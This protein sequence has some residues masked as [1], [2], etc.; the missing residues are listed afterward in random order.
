ME[1]RQNQTYIS[2]GISSIIF[3]FIILCLSVFALLSVNSA[4]QS[5]DSVMRNAE[6]VT[7]YYAADSQ[8][9]RWIH[10]LK[11]GDP[12]D[13]PGLTIYTNDFPHLRHADAARGSGQS[14]IRNPGVSGDKQ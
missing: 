6:A 5:Y 13:T 4:R 7:A 9:Q 14:H 2:I 10:G 8:A 3:I 1:K 12:D 11:T